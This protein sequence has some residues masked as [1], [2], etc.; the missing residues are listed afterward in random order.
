MEIL[1]DEAGTL[2]IDEIGRSD[3][4]TPLAAGYTRAA[5]WLR[6]PLRRSAEAGAE[7]LL[8]VEMPYLDHVEERVSLPTAE[9][10]VATALASRPEIKAAGQKMEREGVRLRYSE[11][12]DQV[13]MNLIGGT[14]ADDSYNST[15]TGYYIGSKSKSPW[16][17][18]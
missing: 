16:W 11:N 12:Q 7:W 8:E 5:F 6:L 17:A 9:D 18:A 10:L 2:T 15:H 3:A 4:F 1:R 14:S 13:E